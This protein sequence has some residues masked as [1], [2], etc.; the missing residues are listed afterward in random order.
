[1]STSASSLPSDSLMIAP[2]RIVLGYAVM[3][4]VAIGLLLIVLTYGEKLTAG[5]GAAAELAESSSGHIEKNLVLYHVLVALVAILLLGRWLGKLFVHFGQPRVI[6][7]MVAGIMLGPSLLG[8]VWPE[9][10][11]FILPTESDMPCLGII[12]Q[13]GVILYMF[14]VGLELNA[15]LLKSRAHATVAIS[16]ASIAGA[17]SAGRDPGAVAVSATW[18]PRTCRSPASPCS[19]ASRCRSPRFPCWRAFLPIAAWKTPSS[20]SW[21]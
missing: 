3:L 17:I 18:R 10:M 2:W 13:I 11:H 19:W 8:R 5:V 7:E 21:R 1:M 12:A 4:V 15:G 9:A 14:L 6:G 16:H 20:A